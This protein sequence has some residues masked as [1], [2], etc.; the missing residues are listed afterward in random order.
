MNMGSD[1]S[2]SMGGGTFPD[3]GAA[4]SAAAAPGTGLDPGPRIGRDGT[5]HHHGAPVWRP[6]LVLVLDGGLETRLD[7]PVYHQLVEPGEPGRGADEGRFGVRSR[8]RLFPL[9]D[10][11]G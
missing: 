6:A 3:Q 8:G 2:L 9:G 7:R 10:V 5:W 1:A 11:E 4:A